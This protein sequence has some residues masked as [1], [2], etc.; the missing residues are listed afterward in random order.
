MLAVVLTTLCASTVFAADLME[1]GSFYYKQSTGGTCTLTSAAMMLRRRAYLDGNADWTSITESS[2]RSAAWS[3]GLSWNF[4]YEGMNVQ[5]GTL[6]SDGNTD[7]LIALLAEH[8]EGIV[9]YNRNN[10][11]AVLLTDYTDGVFYCADPA[12]AAGSG[13]IPFSACTIAMSGVSCYWYIASNANTQAVDVVTVEEEVD[14]VQLYIDS[15]NATLDELPVQE[16]SFYGMFVPENLCVGSKFNL[17]GTLKSPE[18][19]TISEVTIKIID[20]NGN[21]VQEATDIPE[22]GSAEWAFRSLNSDILFGQLT[23]GSYAFSVTAKNSDSTSLYYA[24]A[25]T[26]SG[27]A[28][29]TNY[30]WTA[31]AN[32]VA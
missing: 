24:R 11:H 32:E 30:Y 25:F 21:T 31:L 13:R 18:G 16:L 10:P 7:E 14:E 3:N 27:D 8:P 17:G 5:Y 23:A 2:V 28:T 6:S 20:S 9:A 12:A 29:V 22:E 19:T 4:T 15:V 1:D 26:V